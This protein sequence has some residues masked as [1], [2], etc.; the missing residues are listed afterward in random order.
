MVSRADAE[1]SLSRLRSVWALEPGMLR[2]SSGRARG[3][4]EAGNGGSDLSGYNF[5]RLCDGCFARHRIYYFPRL[6]NGYFVGHRIRIYYFP[7][8]CDG[9]FVG[10]RIYYFPRLGIRESLRRGCSRA[11]SGGDFRWR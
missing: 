5:P 4:D 1:E 10:H 7:R 6:C 3:A 8:L 2:Q 9:Y 11:S